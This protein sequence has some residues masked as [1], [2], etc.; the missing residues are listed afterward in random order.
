MFLSYEVQR[1]KTTDRTFYVKA[2]KFIANIFKLPA[3]G[4]VPKWV[5]SDSLCLRVYRLWQFLCL[6]M[7]LSN[8][9]LPHLMSPFFGIVPFPLPCL[10]SVS[11]LGILPDTRP[12]LVTFCSSLC[13][14]EM[15]ILVVWSWFH[16]SHNTFLSHKPYSNYL[17]SLNPLTISKLGSMDILLSYI[18]LIFITFEKDLISEWAWFLV[19][20]TIPLQW[21]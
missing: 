4:G 19:F 7:P 16:L 20:Y 13:A 14:C 6:F 17:S 2:W 8:L 10:V 5:T 12:S 18:G 9:T 11:K 21:P 1:I 15:N 3:W